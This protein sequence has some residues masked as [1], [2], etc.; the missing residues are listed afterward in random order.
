MCIRDRKYTASAVGEVNVVKT[1][2]KT[3]AVIGGEGNGG[4]IYPE[5][6]YGRDALVGIVMI[7]NLLSDRKLSLSELKETYPKYH[8][9]KSSIKAKSDN[10]VFKYLKNIEKAYLNEKLDKTD[11]LKIL[12]DD[13]WVHIRSSNTEP[14]IRV[15]AE[16]TTT[17]KAKKIV[18][19]I[20]NIINGK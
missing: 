2:K 10:D 1:M 17:A 12:W 7:M 4:V 20:F 18:H 11:G 6:H 15:I 9:V 16:A 5:L 13:A 19:D 8:I 14:I 3:K